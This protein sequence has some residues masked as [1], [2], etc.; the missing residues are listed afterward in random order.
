MACEWSWA[1][2]CLQ[3]HSSVMQ[4]ATQ[5]QIHPLQVPATF[6]QSKINYS[7]IC[8]Q[9]Q[10]KT[11][12]TKPTTKTKTNKQRKS[13]NSNCRGCAVMTLK[14]RCHRDPYF[15]DGNSINSIMVFEGNWKWHN[16]VLENLGG[17]EC[18]SLSSEKNSLALKYRP[19]AKGISVPVVTNSLISLRNLCFPM[20][21]WK[22]RSI[23]QNPF[24]FVYFFFFFKFITSVE[25]AV[26]WKMEELSIELQEW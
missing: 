25:V 3:P 4:A 26:V 1:G 18:A 9:N 7:H 13:G 16:K 6:F 14:D 15:S 12:K 10:N 19:R 20:Y 17:E 8:L 5:M 11:P 21:L 23:V 22:K 24:W 2:N